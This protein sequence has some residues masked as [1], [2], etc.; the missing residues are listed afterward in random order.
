MVSNVKN[1]AATFTSELW[2]LRYAHLKLGFKL[3]YRRPYGSLKCARPVSTTQ[4]DGVQR[5]II[6]NIITRFEKKG[7]KLVAMKL[8]SPSKE[9]LEKHYADLS[10]KKVCPECCPSAHHP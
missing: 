2:L 6:G 10:S 1:C 5:G 8:A 7:F 4:P 9:H 3:A